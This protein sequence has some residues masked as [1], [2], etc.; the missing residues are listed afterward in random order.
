MSVLMIKVAE[1]CEIRGCIHPR[2]LFIEAAPNDGDRTMVTLRCGEWTAYVDLEH[3]KRV[4][5]AAF[6]LWGKSEVSR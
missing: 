1:H 5:N 4:S 6:E 2:D 3:L